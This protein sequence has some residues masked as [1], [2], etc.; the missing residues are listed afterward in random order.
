MNI[1]ELP[2]LDYF[3]ISRAQVSGDTLCLPNDNPNSL[4]LTYLPLPKSPNVNLLG[5]IFWSDFCPV[6]RQ[7]YANIF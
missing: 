7:F 4:Q 1:E 3:I 6:V 2:P 5:D